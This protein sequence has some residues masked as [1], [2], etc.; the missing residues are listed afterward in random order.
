MI[1]S[2]GLSDRSTQESPTH[3]V[4][5]RGLTDHDYISIKSRESPAPRGGIIINIEGPSTAPMNQYSL[6]KTPLSISSKEV[7]INQSQKESI[8]VINEPIQID[9]D[10]QS[11]NNETESVDDE[12][13]KSILERSLGSSIQPDSQFNSL[14]RK[15]ESLL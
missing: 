8:E 3:H 14:N 13:P 2:V 7:R 5:V 10:N 15:S 4:V 6:H 9:N 12:P 11:N 1:L